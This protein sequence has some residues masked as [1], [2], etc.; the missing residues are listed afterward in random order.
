MFD[1]MYLVSCAQSTTLWLGPESIP[2][3]FAAAL[4]KGRVKKKKKRD[5]FDSFE[6]AFHSHES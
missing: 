1:N 4:T 2:L 3:S 5:A 6:T